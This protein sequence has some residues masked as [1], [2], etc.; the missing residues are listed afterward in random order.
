MAVMEV[1]RLADEKSSNISTDGTLCGDR[2]QIWDSPSRVLEYPRYVPY[3]SVSKWKSAIL[4]E[5]KFDT[6]DGGSELLEEK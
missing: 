5:T 3:I 2:D 6:D 1:I 4:P